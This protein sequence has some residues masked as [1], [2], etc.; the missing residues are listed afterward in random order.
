MDVVVK[1]ARPARSMAEPRRLTSSSV[2]AL[3]RERGTFCVLGPFHGG[4][5]RQKVSTSSSLSDSS[6]SYLKPDLPFIM[7]SFSHTILE[8]GNFSEAVKN[9][10]RAFGLPSYFI[11]IPL[12]ESEIP[13]NF[14]WTARKQPSHSRVLYNSENATEIAIKLKTVEDKHS[15]LIPALLHVPLERLGLFIVWAVLAGDK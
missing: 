11:N 14:E 13:S 1:H 3:S 9:G 6:S 8:Q 15:P 2:L 10:L 7:I 4:R 5:E 12:G